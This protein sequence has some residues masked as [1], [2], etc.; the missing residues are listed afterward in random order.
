LLHGSYGIGTSMGSLLVVAALA[1]GT[2]RVA[3]AVMAGLDGALALWAWRLRH[4]WPPDVAAR[5]D[6]PAMS[7]RDSARARP[8]VVIGVTLVCFAVLVGAEYST[9]SWSYTLLTDGRGMNDT[10]AGLWVASYW[11]GLTAARFALAAGG[12]RVR[13]IAVL[14]VGILLALVGVALLW[15]DPAGRG[16]LGL[17]VA[18]VGF[19]N[20]F[21]ALVALMPD[22]VGRRRS[23]SVIGWSVAAASLGG[24]A[25]AAGVGVLVDGHGPAIIAPALAA[26]TATLAA[27]HAVLLRAAPASRAGEAPLA[28]PSPTAQ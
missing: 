19:A 15:I 20:I 2:W 17:P 12:H 21:P 11:I 18:G 23:G 26:V 3:W 16:A 13:P 14:N 1:A 22:R 24:T 25:V 27:V 5:A 9:G 10:A 28:S 7:E 6:S 4:A 8:G